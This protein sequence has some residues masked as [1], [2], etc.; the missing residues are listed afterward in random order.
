MKRLFFLLIIV[1]LA[2]SKRNR[3]LEKT[4]EM[5]SSVYTGKKVEDFTNN[6]RGSFKGLYNYYKKGDSTQPSK[7]PKRSQ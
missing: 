6:M 2:H 3:K 5:Y 4:K 1:F 7:Q